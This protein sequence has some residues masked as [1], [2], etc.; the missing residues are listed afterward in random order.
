[1]LAWQ[2][3]M[4]IA[5]LPFL[6][7]W[8]LMLFLPGLVLFMWDVYRPIA[9]LLLVIVTFTAVCYTLTTILPLLWLNCPFRSPASS[10]LYVW[11]QFLRRVLAFSWVYMAYVLWFIPGHALT[12]MKMVALRGRAA[13]KHPALR[14][15][16]LV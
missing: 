13:T 10:I 5:L 8:S 7:I 12:I 14:H 16:Y 9:I 6:L 3:P 4:I 15:V 2:L 1:M 11:F